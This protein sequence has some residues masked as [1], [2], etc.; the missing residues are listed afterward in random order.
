MGYDVDVVN[1]LFGA[2]DRREIGSL[3]MAARRAGTISPM[4]A[5]S[6]G[7]DSSAAEMSAS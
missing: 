4:P 2:V 1:A 5:V 6:P 3:E 7:H